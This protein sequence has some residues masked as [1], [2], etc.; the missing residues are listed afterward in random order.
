MARLEKKRLTTRKLAYMSA[1]AQRLD[2]NKFK[3]EMCKNW[4]ELRACRYG[5]KC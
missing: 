3:T 1:A 4:I 2:T 5:A